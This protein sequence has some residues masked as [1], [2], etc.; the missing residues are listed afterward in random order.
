MNL[1]ALKTE[2]QTDP[3]SRY[4]GKTDEQ[5]A[6]ALNAPNRTAD[7]ETVTGGMIA[8]SVVRAE[9]AALSN[10]D[11]NYIRTLISAG[12]M[13]ITAQLRTEFGAVFGV[14]TATRTNLIA[15]LK[16]TGSRAEELGLGYVTPSHVADAKRS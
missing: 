13:P 12:E 15:L 2:V 8:A 7:R 9:L 6:E 4:A 10:A 11:Q 16:R 14:G 5:I 3:L 1:A